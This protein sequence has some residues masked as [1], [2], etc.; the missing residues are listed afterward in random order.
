[1][2]ERAK[3]LFDAY[4][5]GKPERSPGESGKAAGMRSAYSYCST[6]HQS[7]FRSQVKAVADKPGGYD[8]NLGPEKYIFHEAPRAHIMISRQ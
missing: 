2:F 6:A 4:C 5:S 7:C 3:A 1:M 8:A